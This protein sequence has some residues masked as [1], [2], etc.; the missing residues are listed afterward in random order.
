M[1]RYKVYTNGTDKVV[2]ASTYAGK[3]VRGTAKCNPGDKFDL[4]IG[5]ELAKLRCDRKIAK[6]RYKRALAKQ[7]EAVIQLVN[8]TINKEK[9]DAYLA[10]ADA[11]LA[12]V[13]VKYNSVLNKHFFK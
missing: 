9:M 1:G 10:D 12:D 3:V 5:I 6:K 2:V 11:C 8:A 4:D 7:A 13:E